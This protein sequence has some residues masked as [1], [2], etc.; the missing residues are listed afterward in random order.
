MLF[1]PSFRKLL[2]R[3]RRL[4]LL[5]EDLDHLEFTW[6]YVIQNVTELVHIDLLYLLLV[7]VSLRLVRVQS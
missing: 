7:V 3:R 5:L 4:E 2:L 6:R 1:L